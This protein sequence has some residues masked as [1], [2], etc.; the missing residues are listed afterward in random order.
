ML[1]VDV[2]VHVHLHLHLHH[3]YHVPSHRVHIQ[4]YIMYDVCIIIIFVLESLRTDMYSVSSTKHTV[5]VPAEAHGSHPENAEA[6][7]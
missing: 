2:H 5:R 1:H 7:M 4:K 3:L 6:Y